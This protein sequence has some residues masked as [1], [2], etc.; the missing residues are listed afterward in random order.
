MAQARTAILAY[1]RTFLGRAAVVGQWF[2]IESG[3]VRAAGGAD[4]EGAREELDAAQ[5]DAREVRGVL[6]GESRGAGGAAGWEQGRSGSL[7]DVGDRVFHSAMVGL[8]LGGLRLGA[9][10][11]PPGYAQIIEGWGGSQGGAGG[12]WCLHGWR[13]PTRGALRALAS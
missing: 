6:G 2:Q 9:Q 11:G 7:S 3:V 1:G 10:I 5:G 4:S 12:G 13:A 8:R